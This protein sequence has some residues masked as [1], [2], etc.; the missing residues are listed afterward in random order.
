MRKVPM[1][2]PAE[3]ASEAKAKADAEAKAKA[4]LKQNWLQKE[5]KLMHAKSNQLQMPVSR[6]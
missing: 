1:Q 3:P 6:R 5:T 4:E 2:M